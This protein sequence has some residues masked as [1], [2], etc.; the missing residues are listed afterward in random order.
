MSNEN[1]HGRTDQVTGAGA[2]AALEDLASRMHDDRP[3]LLL[4]SATYALRIA[5]AASGVGPGDEVLIPGVDS[6]ASWAAVESLGARP[7]PVTVDTATLTIDPRAAAAGRTRRTMAVVACHLHGVPADVPGLRRALPGLS[8]IED[9]AHALG[10]TLDERPVG[11]LGDSAVFSLGPGKQ[12]DAG[13]AGILVFSNLTT[14]QAAVRGAAH[15]ARQAL[16]GVLEPESVAFSLRPHPVA[17]ILGRHALRRWDGGAARL[18]TRRLAERLCHVP[19]VRPIGLD[20]RRC[21]AG[22][23]VPVVL[24]PGRAPRVSG[25]VLRATSARVL[26]VTRRRLL[27]ELLSRTYIAALA[28]DSG[29]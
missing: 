10:S 1:R 23:W 27:A 8:V 7:R 28:S 3:A 22:P 29:R 14:F 4:P 16:A 24:A 6:P 26:G 11:T 2:V 17:A 20:P 5:L 9:C 19:G 13:E 21:V 12:V 18:A 15:P 25:L